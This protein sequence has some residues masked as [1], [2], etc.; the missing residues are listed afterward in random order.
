VDIYVYIMLTVRHSLEPQ[1]ILMTGSLPPPLQL[2]RDKVYH[3]NQA[4]TYFIRQPSLQENLSWMKL[5]VWTEKIKQHPS[6]SS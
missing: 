6:V 3:I 4:S 1:Q 2:A 5:K